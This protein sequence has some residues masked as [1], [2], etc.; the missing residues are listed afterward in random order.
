MN[1][2]I[3]NEDVLTGLGK[4]ESDSVQCCITSPPYDSLRTY[5]HGETFNFEETAKELYRVMCDGGIVCWNIGDSVV[6]GSET[7]TSAKQ[8]IFFHEECGF[9]IHDTM[10]YKKLNFS[11]PEKTRYQQMFEYV[12]ILSKGKPR[13][14]N[15]IFDKPNA[16][17]GQTGWGKN[18]FTN[19]DG[20]KSER[21]K[22]IANEFGMRGNVWEGKTRGQ[23]EGAIELPHP[24]M[25]PKWLCR[26]LMFSWSNKGDTILDPFTGSGTTGE[27]ALRMERKFIGIEL[28]KKYVDHLIIPRLEAVAPLFGMAQTTKG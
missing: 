13:V 20:T 27:I 2:T 12:F 25:M 8:K 5:E 1:Y 18:T 22:K 17:A 28:N 23:E 19:Q 10:I 7:L 3:Y 16:T 6:N 9:R 26:D 15:P 14:F 21:K 24:A 4:I 11:N